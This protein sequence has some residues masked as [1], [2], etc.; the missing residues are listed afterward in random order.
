MYGI[1]ISHYQSPEIVPYN[2]ADFIIVKA[3]EDVMDPSLHLHV[4][5]V[6]AS[7]KV[8]GLYHFYRH[9]VDYRKQIALFKQAADSVE[10]GVGD[11]FPVLDIEASKKN[12]LPNNG[13]NHPMQA[14][15][16]FFAS[17]Y[18]GYIV[19]HNKRD[20][21]LLGSPQWLIASNLWHAEYSNE[22]SAPYEPVM[23]QCRVGSFEYDAPGT[24]IVDQTGIDQ[25]K[26][27]VDVKTLQIQGEDETP[28][29]VK[30]QVLK[31]EADEMLEKIGATKKT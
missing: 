13:W 14:I 18:G 1:D 4:E 11:L 26:M 21:H 22:M 28:V 8:L 30:A 9:G 24:V 17:N 27:L 5:K 20:F 19:Y 15:C 3:T 6:R 12:G 7:A 10:L 16:D 31:T 2:D 25:S 29:A 23:W